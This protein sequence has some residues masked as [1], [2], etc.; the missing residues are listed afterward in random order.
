M[1]VLQ[2]GEMPRNSCLRIKKTDKGRAP[3]R[4]RSVPSRPERATHRRR[5][6]RR[7]PRRATSG[8]RRMTI[9]PR[10]A[11]LVRCRVTS[12]LERHRLGSMGSKERGRRLPL[13]RVDRRSLPRPIPSEARRVTPLPTRR[14]SR[15]P[16]AAK[17]RRRWQGSA[18]KVTTLPR[19]V[20]SVRRRAPLGTRRAPLGRR[21]GPNLPRSPPPRRCHE[22]HL[23]GRR[24]R[25]RRRLRLRRLTSEARKRP[26]SSCLHPT[27]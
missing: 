21:H 4:R 24:R 6:A 8:R 12:R 10:C 2:W 19:R 27:S 26:G 1:A 15:R 3:L 7:L 9:C 20:T 5:H 23:R 11:P 17:R 13:R 18:S 16:S 22:R 14:P 25:G